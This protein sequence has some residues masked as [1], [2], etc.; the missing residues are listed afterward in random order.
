MV[1]CKWLTVANEFVVGFASCHKFNGNVYLRKHFV[2]VKAGHEYASLHLYDE[3]TDG[4]RIRRVET[5]ECEPWYSPTKRL[6][7]DKPIFFY[8]ELSKE[9][10]RCFRMYRW[11]KPRDAVKKATANIVSISQ[12]KQKRAL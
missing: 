5:T 8:Y 12:L 4:T 1:F 3:L 11:A 7:Y 2:P 9:D 6:D 10:D